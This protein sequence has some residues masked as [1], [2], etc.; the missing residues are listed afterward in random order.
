LD[1]VQLLCFTR[2]ALGWVN[3][4]GNPDTKYIQRNHRRGEDAHIQDVSG[5]RKDCRDNEDY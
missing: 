1:A 2:A 5:G 4:P 3:Q